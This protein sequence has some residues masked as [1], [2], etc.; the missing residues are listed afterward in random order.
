MVCLSVSQVSYTLIE[1]K[2]ADQR[3]N[4]NYSDIFYIILYISII[5]E[6]LELHMWYSDF[7]SITS[8]IFFIFLSVHAVY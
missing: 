3:Q 5:H 7:V 1:Q 6:L 2:D 8:C 4:R